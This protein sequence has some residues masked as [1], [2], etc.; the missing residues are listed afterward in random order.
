MS[1][2]QGLVY[3]FRNRGA[4]ETGINVLGVDLCE[5]L[6]GRHKTCDRLILL[7]SVNLIPGKTVKTK[8]LDFF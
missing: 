4:K 1:N 3:F 7:N 6:S 5:T 2:Q 8:I